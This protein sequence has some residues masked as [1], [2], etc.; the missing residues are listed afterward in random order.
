MVEYRKH[1]EGDKED[2]IQLLVESFG[3]KS[4]EEAE[5]VYTWE[6]PRGYTIVAEKEGKV[7]GFISWNINGEFRHE[8]IRIR[9]LAVGKIE[10]RKEI[11]EELIRLAT[12]DADKVLKNKGF[13]LRKVFTL[14]HST[15]KD[16][17][18]FYKSL[19][20]EHESTLKD[21]YYNNMDEYV[22]SLF[23]Q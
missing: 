16:R 6:E 12:D 19:G 20:F 23:F 18:K 13:K 8:L 2:I 21:H 22:M 9:R 10:N 17:M 15:D 7:I 5:K 11:A 14:V 3:I 4:K 1:E